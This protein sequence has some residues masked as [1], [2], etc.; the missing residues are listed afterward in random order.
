METKTRERRRKGVF[1]FYVMVVFCLLL[2]VL[3]VGYQQWHVHDVDQND[4]FYKPCIVSMH[5][6]YFEF[7]ETV[8]MTDIHFNV[9]Y[10]THHISV[11]KQG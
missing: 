11:V 10:P 2:C 8:Y 5:T 3:S 4:M 9:L 1:A 7:V 6:K